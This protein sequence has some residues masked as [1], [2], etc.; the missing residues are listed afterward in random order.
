MPVRALVQSQWLTLDQASRRLGVHPSTLRRWCDEGAISV[1][2]TPGG[3]RRF[4]PAELE[5][6]V[7]EHQHGNLP[8]KSEPSWAAHAIAQARVSL[9]EQR[10]VDTYDEDE[11][12]SQRFLGRRLMGLVLQY[13]AQPGDNPELLTEARIIGVQHAQ[14]ALRR[15][16]SLQD[17]LQAISFF[18]TTMLE[19]ALGESPKSGRGRSDANVHLLRRIERLVAEVQA[20]VV[21]LYLGQGAGGSDLGSGNGSDLAE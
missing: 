2:I 21:E 13:I 6:F 8:V 12:E 10:W 17:L 5:R 3:H 7:V 11:R 20:G 18:R 14:N 9:R 15:G 19:V 4:I 1:F 16:R